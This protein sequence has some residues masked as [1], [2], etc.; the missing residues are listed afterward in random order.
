MKNSQLELM[1]SQKA[2]LYARIINKEEYNQRSTENT[3]YKIRSAKSMQRIEN[4]IKVVG[5]TKLAM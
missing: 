2:C 4:L 5:N 3:L 1:N